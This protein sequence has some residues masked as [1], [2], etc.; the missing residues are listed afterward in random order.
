MSPW[1]EGLRQGEATYMMRR[2]G[3]RREG[4]I[5]DCGMGNRHEESLDTCAM[6]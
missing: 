6:P 1:R 5:L 3:G 4:L 2:R